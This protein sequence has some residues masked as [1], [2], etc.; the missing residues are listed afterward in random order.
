[1]KFY[2]DRVRNNLHVLLCMSPVGDTLASRAR[3][4]PGLITCTTVNWFLPWPTEGLKN[5][6]EKFIV[7]FPMTTSEK[8]KRALMSHMAN[9][10]SLVQVTTVEYFD[11]YRRNVYVTPKSYLSFLKSYQELYTQK[12]SGIKV[13]ADKINNGLTK[14]LEAQDDVSKMKVCMHAY[15]CVYACVGM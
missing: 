11:K 3:K 5:V 13:L 15:T 14:L 12:H 10:H 4:F 9:V 8:T 6:S 1:M 7:D 2:M